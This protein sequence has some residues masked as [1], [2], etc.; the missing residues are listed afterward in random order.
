V[1]A[2][3]YSHR[4]DYGRFNGRAGEI[5]LEKKDYEGAIH[6]LRTSIEDYP[7]TSGAA[8]HMINLGAA[9]EGNNEILEAIDLYRVFQERYPKSRLVSTAKWKLENLLLNKSEELIIGGET[10]EAENLLLELSRSADNPLVREKVFFILGEIFEWRND[11]DMA[12]EYYSKVVHMN[13]GSSGRLVEKAKERIVE[14]EKS[15]TR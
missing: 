10:E 7:D 8:M 13:L 6:Y 3:N 11:K 2:N 1:R 12:I 14:L 5:L 9:Y 4:L 15:R